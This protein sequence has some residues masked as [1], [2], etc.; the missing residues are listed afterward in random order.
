M[1]VEVGERP[2]LERVRLVARLLQVAVV[3][4]SVLTMIVAPFGEVARR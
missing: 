3:N 4:A 2:V 1:Q